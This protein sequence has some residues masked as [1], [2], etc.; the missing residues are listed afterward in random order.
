MSQAEHLVFDPFDP[1]MEEDKRFEVYK[2]ARDEKPFMLHE[3]PRRIWSVFRYED[4]HHIV[5]DHQTFSSVAELKGRFVVL[6][7]VVLGLA[8]VLG[9]W[10]GGFLVSG[11]GYLL[12]LAGSGIFMVL[13]FPL[14]ALV[15]SNDDVRG[16]L[17]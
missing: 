11:G 1:D 2:R 5:Q 3:G 17:A 4:V 7:T 13:N 12:L 8:G 16:G 15:P 14:V 10:L 9:G 6:T